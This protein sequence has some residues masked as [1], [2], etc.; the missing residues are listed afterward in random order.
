MMLTSPHLV[1]DVHK[2]SVIQFTCSLEGRHF[3][4]WTKS[5]GWQQA[6]AVLIDSCVDHSVKDFDGW[7]VTTCIIPDARKGRRIQEKVLEGK[8]V[9]Y[10]QAKDLE[11]VLEALQITRRQLLNDPFAFHSLIDTVYDHLL[12]PD[13]FV[14]PLD[15]RITKAM[16]YIRQNI[17]NTI[18][19]AA[20]ASEVHLSENRFLHLFK[21]QVGAPLRQYVLWQRL[22]AATQAFLEGKSSKEAAYEAGFADPAHFSRTFLQMFG[23]L[24]SSYAALKSLFHFAFFPDV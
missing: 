7:Q 21:E 4:V 14:P 17:H 5:D 18:S 24:P 8:A 6:E 15:E 9:R 1:A 23:A 22:A 2:H 10:L 11:P 3:S 20:V 12:G 16:L 13:A 19:A